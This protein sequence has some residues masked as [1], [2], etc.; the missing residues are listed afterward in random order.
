MSASILAAMIGFIPEFT[1]APGL[2]LFWLFLLVILNAN[3]LIA[4]VVGSLAKLFSLILMPISFSIGQLLLDGPTEGLFKTLVNAPIIAFFGLDYY[5]VTGGQFIALIFGIAIGFIFVRLLST[6]RRKMAEKEKDSNKVH[7]WTKH[8]WLKIAVFLFVGGNKG[9]KT[10]EELLAKRVGNPVRLFGLALVVVSVCFLGITAMFFQGPIVTSALRS[11]LQEA[12]G[13]TV[14]LG[15]ADLDLSAGRLILS[16]LALADPNALQ[17]DLFRASEVEA[18]ISTVNILRKRMVLDQVTIRNGSNGKSR[19]IPGQLTRPLPKDR[20]T[21][22]ASGEDSI[23]DLLENA[24]VWK[25]RLSQLRHWLETLS[26]SDKEVESEDSSG[27]SYQD[28]L[29]ERI[30]LLGYA[31]VRA[32]HLIANTPTALIKRLTAAGVTTTHLEGEILTIEGRNLSTHPNLNSEAPEIS[33]HSDS[34]I[35]AASLRFGFSPQQPDNHI[36]MVY[37]NLSV[38]S[39]AQQLKKKEGSF[40]VNGGTVDISIDGR[41]SSTDSNLPLTLT[42]HNTALSLGGR[43]TKIR[44]LSIPV[45]I[46]GP[47]DNPSIKIDSS[48]LKNVFLSAGKSELTNRLAKELGEKLGEKSENNEQSKNQADAVVDLLGGFLKKK[49]PESS[50]NE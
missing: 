34:W 9:K 48:Q 43:A 30:R 14:D 12:N 25:E 38:D 22:S 16:N 32:K 1:T 6:F 42:L 18:D 44:A 3:L 19:K 26:Q 7:H 46:H 29:E 5:A 50:Q 24:K 47:I 13:A 39:L 41:I 17:T 4:A 23:D 49:K 15:S 35:L 21:D 40:P 10:Y 27:P 37:K 45:T 36:K 2:F 28:Q 33:I 11:G 8:R 31:K 20:K